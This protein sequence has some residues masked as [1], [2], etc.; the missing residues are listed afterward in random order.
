MLTSE[1]VIAMSEAAKDICEHH[2]SLQN[3]IR[4]ARDSDL[5]ILQHARYIAATLPP[6]SARVINE[7]VDAYHDFVTLLN[8][9]LEVK[10]ASIAILAEEG[11]RLKMRSKINAHAA[12]YMRR[13]RARQR[14]DVDPDIIPD[15]SPEYRRRL[16]ANYR[17][18]S[19]GRPEPY[20]LAPS[21]IPS[22]IPP[23][24]GHHQET[25]TNLVEATLPSL[26]EL[27]ALQ[28]DPAFGLQP[29]PPTPS[30]PAGVITVKK[31]SPSEDAA[32][33]AELE[34]DRTARDKADEESFSNSGG[35]L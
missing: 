23:S 20:E 1:S 27:D 31:L 4:A 10:S 16:N 25:P 3:L 9:T 12:R 6:D 2:A 34:A 32:I 11:T 22:S 17:A 14:G 26:D 30:P 5:P 15:T 33:A 18:W 35:I 8:E 19:E 13:Y 7:A 21:S 29:D 28:P 24:G